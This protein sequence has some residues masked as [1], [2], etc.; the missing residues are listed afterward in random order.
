MCKKYRGINLDGNAVELTVDN[1]VIT[2]ELVISETPGL[3]YLL[4]VLVDLQHNGALGEAYNNLLPG[5]DTA[6][7]KIA[8]HLLRHGVGRVLATFTTA[9]YSRLE[10]AATALCGILDNDQELAS[11]FPGIFHEG[12]FISPDAGWR[13][14]HAP[15]FIRKPDWEIFSRLNK[16][17]GN[18]VKVVNVAPEVPGGLEFTARAA[19]AGIKVAM[20]HCHPDRGVIR[21]AAEYGATMITH[22]ANGAAPEIHRFN[23]PFW[24]FLDEP[25]LSP[26][27]VGDGFHLPPEVVRTAIRC[28]GAENCF[29]VS[30]A[31]IYSGCAPGLYHRIGGLDC[32][33]EDNGFIHV[34]GQ[35]ILAG[36]WFQQDRCV[37]FLTQ[38][39]GV[40][41]FTAW[42]M[43]SVYPARIAGIELPLLNCGDEASFVIYENDHIV[44]TVFR[45]VEYSGKDGKK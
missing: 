22:F 38:K 42:K 37:E 24:G 9:D 7:R 11:L 31:N 44:K 18:R 8:E 41:F 33:I 2:S 30:D 20:G 10:R 13:G 1:G 4:P 14:G 21:Q 3:P 28:K 15:E 29:M 17:S 26:G 5:D 16:L 36:A 19:A 35:E 39:C 40:D 43:A 45:G 32:V 34:A 25:A 12:V 27:L 6:L 23:N